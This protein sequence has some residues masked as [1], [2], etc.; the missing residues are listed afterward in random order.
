MKHIGYLL[1][2]SLVLALFVV[3]CNR[4]NVGQAYNRDIGKQQASEQGVQE[5]QAASSTGGCDPPCEGDTPKC[6][7]YKSWPDGRDVYACKAKCKCDEKEIKEHVAGMKSDATFEVGYYYGTGQDSDYNSPGIEFWYP[8][9]ENVNK[10]DVDI[11]MNLKYKGNTFSAI[12]GTYL[13]KYAPDDPA[14]TQSIVNKIEEVSVPC[15]PKGCTLTFGGN[16]FTIPPGALKEETKLIV[17]KMYYSWEV[18]DEK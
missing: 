7:H 9:L 2:M 6:C 10:N 4:E 18:L 1:I 11:Q 17:E 15:G 8:H 16:S 14:V 5:Q 12:D 3:G 13:F